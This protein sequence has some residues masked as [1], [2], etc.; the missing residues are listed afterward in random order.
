MISL[1]GGNPNP[2]LF[3]FS[4]LKLRL[5][6]G[7]ELSLNT[8]QVEEA[9][10][11][12]ATKGL[13]GL[14]KTLTELQTTEHKPQVPFEVMVSAGSQEGLTRAF[15]ML[16]SPGDTLLVEQP[17]YSGALAFLQPFGK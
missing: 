4:D 16:L 5:K 11:Y 2:A 15:E 10:Q 8:S 6:S 12:S 14:V 7:E 3:P 9:C 17:T 13:P 1:G